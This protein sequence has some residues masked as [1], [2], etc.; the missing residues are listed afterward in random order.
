MSYSEQ[1]RSINESARICWTCGNKPNPANFG[2]LCD[3]CDA[4][5][6]ARLSQSARILKDNGL[7]ETQE[8]RALRHLGYAK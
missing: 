1:I 3:P 2:G 6:K 5:R 7:T 4:A 8:Y